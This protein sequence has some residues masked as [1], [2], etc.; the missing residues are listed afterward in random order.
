MLVLCSC[1]GKTLRAAAIVTVLAVALDPLAQ[2]LVQLD[3]VLKLHTTPGQSATAPWA[4][5]Y[6]KGFERAS[7]ILIDPCKQHRPTHC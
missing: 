3:Q 7:S 2:Q 4:S 5:R 1:S 6:S